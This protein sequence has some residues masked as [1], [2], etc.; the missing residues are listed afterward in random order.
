MQ[1]DPC[2]VLLDEMLEAFFCIK[3]WADGQGEEA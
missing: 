1:S 3:K 2:S